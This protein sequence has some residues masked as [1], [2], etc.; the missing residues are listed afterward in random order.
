MLPVIRQA[1]VGLH[2]TQAIFHLAQSC[3]ILYNGSSLLQSDLCGVDPSYTVWLSGRRIGL[4]RGFLVCFISFA[5]CDIATWVHT[6]SS[7]IAFN[8]YVIDIICYEFLW[9]DGKPSVTVPKIRYSIQTSST[10]FTPLT[11]PLNSSSPLLIDCKPPSTTFTF[12]LGT[13]SPFSNFSFNQTPKM[14]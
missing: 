6:R 14:N 3:G 10:S 5:R 12:G 4:A 11:P 2:S 8:S 7:K 13:N 9:C 1:Q